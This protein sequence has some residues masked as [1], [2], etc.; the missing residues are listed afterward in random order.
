MNNIESDVPAGKKFFAY[1]FVKSH[2]SS[3]WIFIENESLGI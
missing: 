3:Y 1:S 2:I